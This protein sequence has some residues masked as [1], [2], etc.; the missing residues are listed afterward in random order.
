MNDV[1]LHY[2]RFI[3]SLATTG[4]GARWTKACALL[5]LAHPSRCPE[6]QA[7]ADARLSVVKTFGTTRGV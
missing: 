7:A 3:L 1:M 6:R 5:F 2:R 4:V